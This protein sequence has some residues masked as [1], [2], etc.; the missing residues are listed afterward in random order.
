MPIL[1]NVVNKRRG[2]YVEQ[3][4]WGWALASSEL[5]VKFSKE[6]AD[7]CHFF[8]LCDWRDFPGGWLKPLKFLSRGLWI[9]VGRVSGAEKV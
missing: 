6:S 3:E 1:G 8:L 9:P 4:N 2:Q 5:F 7:D